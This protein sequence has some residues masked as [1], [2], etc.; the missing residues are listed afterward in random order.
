[1]MITRIPIKILVWIFVVPF[2]VVFSL[3]QIAGM[4]LIPSISY[5]V[6]AEAILF[7]ALNS[8]GWWRVCWRHRKE[9]WV[10]RVIFPDLQGTYKGTLN[11][12]WGD[13]QGQREI[14]I[15]IDQTLINTQVFLKSH[16]KSLSDSIVCAEIKREKNGNWK[17]YYAY[18]NE[19]RDPA[20]E[21]SGDHYGFAA[22]NI[23]IANDITLSGRYFTDRKT[24][25]SIS[26]KRVSRETAKDRDFPIANT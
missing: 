16:G 14:D 4:E 9:T 26:V 24:L 22:L 23:V 19:N 11:Y 8:L 6:T 7:M 18:F 20:A 12:T 15:V 25:G 5:A 2:L 3:M 1:M 10:N 13:E 17:I 21:N